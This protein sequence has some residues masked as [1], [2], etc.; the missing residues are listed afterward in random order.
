MDETMAIGLGRPD[1]YD[2]NKFIGIY[3]FIFSILPYA[4]KN[5]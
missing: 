1:Y 3:F 2:L 4:G 5:S